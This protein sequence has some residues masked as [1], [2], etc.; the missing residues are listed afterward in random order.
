[1]EETNARFLFGV[2][3]VQQQHLLQP[4]DRLDVA[5][6]RRVNAER[7]NLLLRKMKEMTMRSNR[8]GL[9]GSIH[10]VLLLSENIFLSGRIACCFQ[11]EP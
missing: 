3:Q 8:S 9:G 4:G 7:Y 1:M 10:V 6:R 11:S 2:V 5:Q